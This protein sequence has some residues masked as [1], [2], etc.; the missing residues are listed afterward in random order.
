MTNDEI[1][2][3][4]RDAEALLTQI[5]NSNKRS[6]KLRK[7]LAYVRRQLADAAICWSNFH[8]STSATFEPCAMPGRVPDFASP[9]GSLY[10]FCDYRQGVIRASD[11]WG[12]G[13]R[14]CDWYLAGVD[15][16]CGRKGEWSGAR[17]EVRVGFVEFSAMK[18]FT[19]SGSLRDSSQF[20][21]TR[22]L[23]VVA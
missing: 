5:Y 16:G 14:S 9:S 7:A 17:G 8:E 10:W 11:H 22:P 3:A 15:D 2:R 18:K 21:T 4:L 1:F 6:Q 19:I 13:I 12:R 20:D 23:E